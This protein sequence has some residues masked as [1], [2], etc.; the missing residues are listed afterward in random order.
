MRTS[1]ASVL[2]LLC[3]S[4]AAFAQSDYSDTA[5][6]LKNFAGLRGSISFDSAISAKATVPAAGGAPATTNHLKANTDTGFGGSVYWG[7]RLPYGFKTELE[8]LYRRLSLSDVTLNGASAKLSGPAQ[9]V[10]PMANI[11]WDVPVGDFGVHPFIGGGLG[12]AW[13]EI[14]VHNLG[15]SGTLHDDK[16]RFA[17]NLMAGASIPLSETSRLSAMYRWFHEDIA[18]ACGA[19]IKCGGALNSQSIDIGL[20]FDM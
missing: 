5:S 7:T 8:V 16:W 13:N 10:A 4:T 18:I 15:A 19:V 20:E 9:L 2:V 1:I 6:G 17:Y 3:V 14:G 12:Y 11:Y